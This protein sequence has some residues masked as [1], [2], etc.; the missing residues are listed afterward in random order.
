LAHI[1]GLYCAATIRRELFVPPIELGDLRRNR[2][3]RAAIVENVVCIP[4]PAKAIELGRHDG[5]DLRRRESA[6]GDDST[7]LLVLG[8]IDHQDPVHLLGEA[9]ALE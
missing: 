1:A 8:A 5:T 6:A 4:Q 7:N 2:I 3:G 9:A